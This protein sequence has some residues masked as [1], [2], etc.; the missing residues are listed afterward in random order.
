MNDFPAFLSE[1]LEKVGY[2]QQ[3]I[4]DSIAQGDHIATDPQRIIEYTHHFYALMECQGVLWTRL[5]LMKNP[6]LQALSDAIVL[7]CD[8]LGR[9]ESETVD[10][11]H[12]NMK[13]ECLLCLS[14][15]TG[16]DL[17]NYEGIDVDFRWG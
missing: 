5:K 1:E 10:D 6:E 12:R 8:S 4:Q 14:E 13:N 11:F 9:E 16:E 15:L 17:S 3:V 7:V 2:L